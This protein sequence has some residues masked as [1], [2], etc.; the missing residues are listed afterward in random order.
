MRSIAI[1]VCAALAACVPISDEV[2]ESARGATSIVSGP[3]SGLDAGAA[4][5]SSLHFITR[6]YG[7]EAVKQ[8]SAAAEDDYSRIMVDTNLFSF[9]PRGLYEVWVY[10]DQDE[11]RRKTRQPEW[12]GGVTVGNA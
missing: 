11:Y 3:F 2:P 8:V 5:L 4:E 10:A 1:A 12:S 9:M 7:S 6:G